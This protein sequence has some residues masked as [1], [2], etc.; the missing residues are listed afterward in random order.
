MSCLTDQCFHFLTTFSVSSLISLNSL[1]FLFPYLFFFKHCF[2]LLQPLP[3]PLVSVKYSTFLQALIY[4]RIFIFH[5]LHGLSCIYLTEGW[6]NLYTHILPYF[7]FYGSPKGKFS[8]STLSFTLQ[9][10]SSS[11][12]CLYFRCKEVFRLNY[13]RF[14]NIK[15]K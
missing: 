15:L 6:H 13:T 14:I 11:F 1:V 7:V 3:A 9:I 12:L 8:L 2:V 10:L 5:L 4:K